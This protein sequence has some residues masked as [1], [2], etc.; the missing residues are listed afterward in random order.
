MEKNMGSLWNFI[1]INGVNL[2]SR[3]CPS[4]LYHRRLGKIQMFFYTPYSLP[5]SE[6]HQLLLGVKFESNISMRLDS[7]SANNSVCR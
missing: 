2:C 7:S 4:Y 6:P 5:G 3:P 1:E